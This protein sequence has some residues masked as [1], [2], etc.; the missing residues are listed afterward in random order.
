MKKLILSL[1]AVFMIV[2]GVQAQQTLQFGAVTGTVTDSSGAVVVNAKIVAENVHGRAI[3]KA[4][5][6]Q[7]GGYQLSAIPAA[8]YVVKVEAEGFASEEK[9]LL[10]LVEHVQELNFSLRPTTELQETPVAV[11]AIESEQTAAQNIVTTRDLAGKTPGVEIQRAGISPLTQVF[12]I[13]GIGN[14]DPI[15]DPNVAQYLDDIYL[16][17]TI[18]GLSDLTD[19]DRIEVLRGPQG[20]LFGENADAGA[21]R[22]ISKTPS[23]RTQVKIDV[24][25]GDYNTVNAHAYLTGAIRHNLLGSFAAARDQHDGYTWDPTISRHVND[26]QTTDAR[27]KLLATPTQ[28]LTV[29]LTLDGL[30]DRSGGA[31]YT[32]KQPII[33]GTLANPIY[34]PFKP[35][36]SYVSVPP[37]NHS[38]SDGVTLKLSYLIS[39]ALIFHSISAGR[40]FH[41][42]PVD[43]DNVG[44]AMVPFNSTYSFP[45]SINNNYIFYREKEA[46][47]EFQLQG[48][49]KKFDF[50]SGLYFLYEDFFNN[51]TIYTLSSVGAG[52]PAYPQSQIGNNGTYN[53]SAY[54]QGNY[55]FTR[56]LILTLGGRYTDVRRIFDFQG[57]WNELPTLISAQQ[58]P[59]TPLP[60]G[61]PGAP[62]NFGVVGEAK[63]WRSFTP[64]AGV[65]YQVTP[66]VFGYFSF[67]E[68]FDAGGYNNRASSAAALLPYNQE[69]VTTY[70]FGFRTE[71]LHERFRFNPTFFYNDYTDL[72][73]AANIF[74]DSGT[75]SARVNAGSAHTEGFELETSAA[76]FKNL[77]FTGTASY[78]NTRFDSF[79]VSSLVSATGNQLPVSPHWQLFGG[80]SYVLPVDHLH[81][82]VRLG[83]DVT[84]ETSY[85]SDI[86]NYKQ[87]KVTPQDF[88]DGYISYQPPTESRLIFSLSAKNIANTLH[89]QS[90]TWGGSPNYWD[91][92][93]APP[94]TVFLKA[95]YSF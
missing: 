6:N 38:R 52:K 60:T 21:I 40:S 35:N 70:E 43:Y 36:V 18:N 74:T 26:Q 17:R 12:F 24:G 86:Y 59:P 75:V 23:E 72:Q 45:V 34:G 77:T 61:T 80:V 48:G 88:V 73:E 91:G 55:H 50:T 47:Q 1:A 44:Q 11:Q 31:Y 42:D 3:Y 81:N 8:T 82:T 69:K 54:T 92:P 67:A 10:I 78:L 25:Y 5:T 30:I 85:Y 56:K 32:P 7:T 16:P 58:L 27:A 46:T 83:A 49:W 95:A 19:L 57:I 28:A 71:A 53:Y 2:V 66:G 84:Y 62:A 39:P 89:Y 9:T 65:S 76:P 64:K 41:Q 79:N 94:R 33:G 20:T 68:G 87:G 37:L 29:L 13:R 4:T 14:P 93:M 22:Y 15:L 90:I 63:S 51:R